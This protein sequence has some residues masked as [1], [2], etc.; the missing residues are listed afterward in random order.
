MEL[1]RQNKGYTLNIYLPM[2]LMAV[3]LAKA[4]A[5]SV[6]L[7]MALMGVALAIPYL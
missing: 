7:P 4:I 6:Y 1:R 3:A 2:A 5:I